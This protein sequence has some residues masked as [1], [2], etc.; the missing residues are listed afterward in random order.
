MLDY[1]FQQEGTELFCQP[2]KAAAANG[3]PFNYVTDQSSFN[4]TLVELTNPPIC[5]VNQAGGKA[6][7]YF[8]GTVNPP[9]NAAVFPVRC[10]WMVAK[11]TGATFGGY[12][13]LLSDLQDLGV[14]VGK[15]GTANFFDF[16]YDLYEYRTN[17]RIYPAAAA[18]APMDGF[19]LL[20][21]RFWQSVTFQG[22]QI[23]QDRAFSN[24][25]L[26]GFIAFLGLFSRDFCEKDIRRHSDLIAADFGLSPLADVY[27]YQA[28][29]GAQTGGA[30]AVFFDP[31]QGSRVSKI[32]NGDQKMMNLRFSSRRNNEVRA[33]MDYHKAH[34]PGVKCIY[35]DYNLTPP[36]DLSG[37]ISSPYTLNG[38][39]NN[40]EYSF[41][42]KK[43]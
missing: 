42:F 10:G 18:P 20:F 5:S 39:V 43:E 32:L 24:R 38:S 8:D 23:G 16:G 36:V 14:F 30:E 33:M 26:N 12:P 25:K 29:V 19:K 3:Q 7:I 22:V 28:N 35:R 27:P 9:K 40:Y 31:R 17:D 34:F 13:G 4:R 2:Y 41:D 6:A 1:E 21:F 15:S 11:I 37:Y